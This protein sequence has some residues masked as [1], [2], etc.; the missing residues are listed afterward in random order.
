MNNWP[1]FLVLSETAVFYLFVRDDLL[2]F[3]VVEKQLEPT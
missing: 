3:K 1:Q 2:Q